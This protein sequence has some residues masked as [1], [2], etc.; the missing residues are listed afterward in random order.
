MTAAGR[1]GLFF[2]PGR[3]VIEPPIFRFFLKVWR[4]AP[5]SFFDFTGMQSLLMKIY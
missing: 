4:A 5:G 2:C 3:R 1:K